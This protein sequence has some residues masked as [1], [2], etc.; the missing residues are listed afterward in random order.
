MNKQ[1]I[2]I[3]V[4][5]KKKEIDD[6]KY[7]LQHDTLTSK[8]KNDL[9]T[10]IETLKKELSDFLWKNNPDHIVLSSCKYCPGRPRGKCN[11]RKIC[12]RNRKK[13]GECSCG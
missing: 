3:M 10:T 6:M 5:K 8:E 2:E 1:E 9:K 11:C 12:K 13:V 7:S 4:D